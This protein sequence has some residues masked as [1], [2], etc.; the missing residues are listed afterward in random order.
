[1]SLV[2]GTNT[3]A[4]FAQDALRSNQRKTATAMERLSTGIRINSAR[5]DAAGLAI[6]QSMTSQIRGLNQAVRN[7][8]DGVNLL[9]TAEGGLSSI[10]DM[11]QRMRELAVQSANG[12]YSGSQRAY[13][14]KEATA[15]QEQISKVVDTTTWND[16]KLLDG[17]FTE[18]KIQVGAD[19]GETMNLSI[20]NIT[21]LTQS[22]SANAPTLQGSLITG[23]QV[24]K[25]DVSGNFAFLSSYGNGNTLDIVDISN[26]NSPTKVGTYTAPSS[27]YGISVSGNRAY[28]TTS[29]NGL[30]VLDIS[31]P[32][33][34]TLLGSFDNA[35]LGYDIKVKGNYAYVADYGGN[36]KV[37]NVSNPAS[38]SQI[39]SLAIGQYSNGMELNGDFAFVGNLYEGIKIIDVSNPASP[40]LS[41]T[42]A[43]PGSYST[44]V[45]V[46]GNYAYVPSTTGLKIFDIS[47]L[48]AP[49]LVGSSSSIQLQGRV[50]LSGSTLYGM[51]YTGGNMNL[52]SFNV[53]D[54][55]N[56]SLVS[57]QRITGN[58]GPDIRTSGNY[59]YVGAQSDG[60]KIFQSGIDLSTASS[61][62][63]SIGA[64]DNAL[65]T[66]NST[67]STIGSYINRLN[68]AA[69]NATNISTNIAAS[70]SVI[71]DTDYAEESANLAKSQITQ[72]AAT[73]M[74]AQANQQPQ[75]VLALLKNI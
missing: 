34:P 61:S 17:S 55:T 14:Q 65:S 44:S 52:L 10:T 24:R 42:I 73:A 1:M 40:T 25:V 64:I 75:A 35:T 67:R 62:S 63:N 6:S 69:D 74:L 4:Q 15:L 22:G 37:F 50:A 39:G 3:S 43:M 23:N 56:P 48:S 21:S 28:L 19:S 71:Q 29:A 5:D 33:S 72:Q 26:P 32:S 49:T 27:T 2:V 58:S 51:A 8:N 45:A 53:S 41:S 7:I 70:R 59:L 9:Q 20:S 36:L 46:A 13:L 31:N 38:I 18:Q 16:K 11:L 54:P 30:Q 57:S 60:L 66:V 47:N 68:Y 12:T